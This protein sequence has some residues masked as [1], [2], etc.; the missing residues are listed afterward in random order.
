MSQQG[1]CFFFVESM[2]LWECHFTGARYER[3]GETLP[4]S[5]K[6]LSTALLMNFPFVIPAQAGIQCLSLWERLGEG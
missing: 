2:I 5:L 6:D 1:L 3:N 4:L